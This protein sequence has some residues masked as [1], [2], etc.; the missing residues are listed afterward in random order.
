MA[1]LMLVLTGLQNP[2]QV[3]SLIGLS[4]AVVHRHG[5]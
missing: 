4:S 5:I 1:S 3:L 2:A